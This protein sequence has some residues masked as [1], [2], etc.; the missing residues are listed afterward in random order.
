MRPAIIKEAIHDEQP[1]QKT[2][3]TNINYIQYFMCI[4]N[5]NLLTR[6]K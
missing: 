4:L 1:N 6:S 5:K 2:K 3:T